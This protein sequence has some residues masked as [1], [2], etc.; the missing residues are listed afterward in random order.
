MSGRAARAAREQ[1]AR[2]LAE[3][4]DLMASLLRLAE[5]FAPPLPSLRPMLDI[6]KDNVAPSGNWDGS[7]VYSNIEGVA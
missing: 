1:K 6:P 2:E 5:N 3:W 4:R 7:T